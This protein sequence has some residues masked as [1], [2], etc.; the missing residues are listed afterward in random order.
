MAVTLAE[1]MRAVQQSDPTLAGVIKTYIENAPILGDAKNIGAPLP[2]LKWQNTVGGIVS[3]VRQKT[4]PE[5]AWR[6]IGTEFEAKVGETEKISEDLKIGGGRVN[7]DRAL[8][9][10]GGEAGAIEQQRMLVASFARTWN[11][12]FYKGDGSN[13]S[14][15][16]LEERLTDAGVNNIDNGGD[17]L[18]LYVLDKIL[19]EVRGSDLAIVT[20]R[21]VASR[22]MQSAKNS[23]NVNYTPATYGVSPASYNGVPIML[24]GEDID[25]SE[26]LG[27]TETAST[28]SIYVVSLGEEGVVGAQTKPMEVIYPQGRQLVDSPMV[29]EWDNNFIIKNPRSA[30]RLRNIAD[31]PILAS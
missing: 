13:N 12:A 1:Y 4:L 17:A 30:I 28:A 21:G 15:T 26:I 20:G 6:E 9:N 19:L 25:E 23:T 31:E 10:R 16:G 18:D 7:I 3:F 24:A 29:V 2:S 8:I 22:I 11:K 5:T 27:F 14:I